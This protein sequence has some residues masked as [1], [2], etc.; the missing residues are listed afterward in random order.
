MKGT[1]ENKKEEGREKSKEKDLLIPKTP[2]RFL[3]FLVRPFWKWALLAFVFVTLGQGLSTALRY[4]LKVLIDAVENGVQ[5]EFMLWGFIFP[6]VIAVSWACWRTAGFLAVYFIP[7]FQVYGYNELFAYLAKHSDS[8]FSNR[9][10]GAINRK[11]SRAVDKSID[12]FE[13]IIWNYFPTFVEFVGVVVLTSMT[14]LWIG[15]SILALYILLLGI[16]FGFARWRRPYVVVYAEKSSELTGGIV[17]SISNM[18][19]VHQ[20]A[21]SV[22]E[23]SKVR[24][25]TESLRAADIAH[26]VRS[27]WALAVNAV[28]LVSSFAFVTWVSLGLWQSGVISTGDLVLVFSFMI[29]IGQALLFIGQAMSGFTRDYG[30]VQ[31]GLSDIIIP[32]EIV[33]APNAK[34]LQ[35]DEGKIELRDV[36]FHYKEHEDAPVVFENLSLEIPADQKVGLVGESGAGKS[37]LVSLLLRQHD[38]LGG[39]IS[40]DGQNIAKVTQD[41]LRENIAFVPQEPLL[42][43]RTIAENIRYGKLD[44][45]DAE[46]VEAAKMA[47]AHDFIEATPKGYETKVGERGIKLSG[48]Q[49]QRIAI[50]RAILKNAPILILDEATSSLDSESEALIQTALNTLMQGK[51]VIAIAHRLSTLRKM[52][53]IVVLEE[54][55]IVE[56]GTHKELLENDGTFARLWRHQAGGFLVEE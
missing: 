29:T 43:H 18:R 28:V 5:D 52:D 24:T 44:A 12:L 16:N 56:D 2:M 42:F 10:G 7:R 3:W 47:Q 23:R 35:V 31:E 40:V 6:V 26:S 27:E 14:H 37:T 46:V 13:K 22:F 54:G 51:T 41:S 17:D 15:M 19:A 50:A 39:E 25:L 30:E 21:R 38:I 36:Q 48:G 45:T 9:F 8:Y 32:H 34:K 20:F 4:I 53:R 1:K 55:K 33:D 49:R 11:L